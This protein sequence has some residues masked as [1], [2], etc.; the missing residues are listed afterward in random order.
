MNRQILALSGLTCFAAWDEPRG[1]VRIVHGPPSTLKE[2]I[3]KS[4]VPNI[5]AGIISPAANTIVVVRSSEDH[6]NND[7]HANDQVTIASLC[8]N[9]R[10]EIFESGPTID[11]CKIEAD[12]LKSGDIAVDTD[13]KSGL[14]KLIR[15]AHSNGFFEEIE[16]QYD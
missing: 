12:L 3:L 2:S 1:Q 4:L 7:N 6:S 9:S 11:L 14:V 8:L 10:E 13:S 15:L 16:L 5:K